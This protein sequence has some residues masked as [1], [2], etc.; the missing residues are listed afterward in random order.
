MDQDI[1]KEIK[2]SAWNYGYAAAYHSRSKKTNPF[3]SH[4]DEHN[5]WN[6]G[7]NHGLEDMKTDNLQK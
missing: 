4:V 1:A 6:N 7:H 2:E 3:Y 5:D